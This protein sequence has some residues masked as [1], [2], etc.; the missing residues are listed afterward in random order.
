MGI[1]RYYKGQNP[2]FMHQDL[3]TTFLRTKINKIAPNWLF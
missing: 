3:S 1:I 2:P